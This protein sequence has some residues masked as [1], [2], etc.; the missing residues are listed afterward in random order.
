MNGPSVTVRSRMDSRVSRTM[1]GIGV[2]PTRGDRI[3]GPAAALRVLSLA[4]GFA[5]ELLMGHERGRLRHLARRGKRR[6]DIAHDRLPPALNDQP[7]VSIG[8]PAQ[9]GHTPSAALLQ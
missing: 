1:R 8:L 6:L 5:M 7:P 4:A 3:L 2:S 9:R